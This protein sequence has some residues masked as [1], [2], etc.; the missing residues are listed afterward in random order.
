MGQD[1]LLDSSQAADFFTHLNLGMTVGFQHRLGQV[2][3]E[4]VGAIAYVWGDSS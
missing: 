2:A 1:G 3:E 4:M